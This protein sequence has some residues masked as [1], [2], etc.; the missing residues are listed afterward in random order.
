MQTYVP[1]HAATLVNG[2][3]PAGKDKKLDKSSDEQRQ[4]TTSR[5]AKKS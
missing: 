2:D 1:D 4:K 3:K 5:A